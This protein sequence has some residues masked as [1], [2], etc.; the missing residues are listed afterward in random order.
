MSLTSIASRLR[1]VRYAVASL[2]LQDPAPMKVILWLSNAAAGQIPD[3]LS[4]LLGER[5]EIRFREDVGPHTKLI[6]ALQEFP[7]Q[8]LVTADDD[9][10]Y[11]SSWLGRLW[12]EHLSHPGDVIGHEC[13]VISA[14]RRS[15]EL[16][17]YRQWPSAKPGECA[18]AL[19]PLGY[20]GVLYPPGCLHPEATDVGLFRALA[21]KADDLWFKAMSLIN[22]VATR[23]SSRPGEKPIPVPFS[24]GETLNSENVAQDRNRAQWLALVQH[25]G[26]DLPKAG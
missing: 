3:N 21:P 22:G 5:F 20:S 12:D 24:Q 2:L 4:R 10:L 26:F 15:G 9:M 25:Y 16:L 13:R 19:L 7:G 8:V 23:R 11:E 18:P 17:P 1:F 6:Y 14:D